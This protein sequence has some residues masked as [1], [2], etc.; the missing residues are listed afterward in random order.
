MF[1]AERDGDTDRLLELQREDERCTA[2][3]IERLVSQLEAAAD[4]GITSD[5]AARV[6]EREGL[7]T[8][9]A[10]ARAILRLLAMIGLAPDEIERLAA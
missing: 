3:L 4:S 2:E 9:P 8:K 10:K 5:E 7:T 1:R 6:L